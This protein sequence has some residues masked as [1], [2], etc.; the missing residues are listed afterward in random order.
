MLFSLGEASNVAALL[1]PL[2]QETKASIYFIEAIVR[3]K[4]KK[5]RRENETSKGHGHKNS[6][7]HSLVRSF[8]LIVYSL[9]CR[10]YPSGC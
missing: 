10:G 7:G 6:M 1:D 8:F 3:E 5:Y 4:E 2:Y 9:Y